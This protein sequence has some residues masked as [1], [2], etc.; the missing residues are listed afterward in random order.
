MGRL[1]DGI[2]CPE[3]VEGEPVSCKVIQKNRLLGD[4]IG[5]G[6]EIEPKYIDTL[7]IY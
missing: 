4:K 3:L 2:I 6:A 7:L 1:W 5:E